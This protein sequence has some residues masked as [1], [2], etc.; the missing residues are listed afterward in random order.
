ML[1]TPKP[2]TY[3]YWFPSTYWN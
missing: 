2:L 3:F 1:D